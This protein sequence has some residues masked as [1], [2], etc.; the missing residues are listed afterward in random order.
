MKQKNALFSKSCR[1]NTK[2]HQTKDYSFA[3]LFLKY[4]GKNAK[5]NKIW[6]IKFKPKFRL[7]S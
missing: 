5:L 6:A 4:V 3:L 7:S 2:L 1:V